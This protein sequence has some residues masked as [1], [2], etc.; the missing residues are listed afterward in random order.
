MDGL[1]YTFNGL[2]EYTMIMLVSGTFQ[3]QART[4]LAK[5]PGN[6]TVLCAV[7]ANETGSS[8]VQMSLTEEGGT[9]IE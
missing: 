8:T 7:A 4:C 6:G 5:G 9:Y 2:G 3:M 1:S